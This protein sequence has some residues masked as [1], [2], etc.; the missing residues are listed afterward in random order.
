ML[1]RP[2]EHFRFSGSEVPRGDQRR[3]LTDQCGFEGGAAAASYTPEFSVQRI[4]I[5]LGDLD[6]AIGQRVDEIRP[7]DSSDL[8][9]ASL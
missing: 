3:N 6:L 4:E 2:S 5:D 1:V 8:G 7:W 9:A